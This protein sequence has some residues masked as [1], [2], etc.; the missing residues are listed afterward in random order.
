MQCLIEKKK[1]YKKLD[2]RHNIVYTKYIRRE[3]I[4]MT[5]TIQKWGNSQGI[6]I[7]KIILDTVNW[8]EDE[9]IMI[10]VDNGKIVMEKA[11]T[12]RKNIKEL[13]ENYKGE[14]EPTEIDWGEP[15]GEEIW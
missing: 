6:R 2:K 14:Y 4:K 10:V 13:F 15:K 9:Q 12:K 1:M 3:L 5:T 7:P 8:S 11:K